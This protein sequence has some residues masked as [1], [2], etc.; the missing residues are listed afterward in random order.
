MQPQSAPQPDIPHIRAPRTA[1]TNLI[2]SQVD[3]PDPQP[4]PSEPLPESDF[5]CKFGSGVQ[6]IRTCPMIYIHIKGYYPTEELYQYA[7]KTLCPNMQ[8]QSAPQPEP[9]QLEAVIKNWLI[10]F[11]NGKKCEDCP[12]PR[13]AI[14][15]VDCVTRNIMQA[16]AV[17]QPKC[18]GQMPLIKA[19]LTEN[20]W[21]D[22]GFIMGRN[23]QRDADWQWHLADKAEAIKQFADKCIEG[24]PHPDVVMTNHDL[25]RAEE[26]EKHSAH[27]RAMAEE[28]K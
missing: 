1:T 21:H 12:R 18:E 22:E 3:E 13:E 6:D 10:P 16:V 2:V 7:L 15:C 11:M 8:P 23:T 14:T 5:R 27:I 19:P 9:Q 24:M 20:Y 26:Y 25:I 17:S 4:S 28:A